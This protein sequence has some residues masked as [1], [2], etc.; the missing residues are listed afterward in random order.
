MPAVSGVDFLVKAN[1]GTEG[2]P[3]Y[4]TIGGQRNCTLNL[5]GDG[6]D[7][8]SKDSNG[9]HEEIAGINNWSIDFD[10]L[11]LEDDAAYLELEDAYMNRQLLLVQ[12]ATPGGKTYTGKAR[13]TLNIEGPYDNEAT[14]SGTLTGSGALQ[15]A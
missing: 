12:L 7:T 13:V 10:A 5:D 4:T 11:A 14:V 6:I 15:K 1:T 9:W 8:T 2:A 3:V